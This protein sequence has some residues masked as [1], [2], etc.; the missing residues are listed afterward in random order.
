MIKQTGIIILAAGNSSRLGT[1]K[2]LLRFEGKCLLRRIVD[3]ASVH[4]DHRVLVVLG[5]AHEII[6][7]ELVG[8]KVEVVINADWED[9]MSGSIRIGLK[10]LLQ[11]NPD[12]KQCIVTVCDQPFINAGVF[13]ELGVLAKRTGKGIITTGFAGTWGVPVLFSQRYFDELLALDGQQGAKKVVKKHTE[14]MAMFPFEPARFDVDTKAD[15]Y[16]LPHQLVSVQEAGEI[17]ERYLPKPKKN[18]DVPIQDAFGYTL[19]S[20]VIAQYAIPD[21]A[22]S[23][24]DGYAIRHGELALQLKVADKIPA[25]TTVRKTLSRGEA[26]RIFTG[27]P[28]PEGA[29]TVVMQENVQVTENG[30]IWIKDNELRPGDNVRPKGSEVDKGALAIQSGTLL[31][32]AAIGYLAGVGCT[33][34]DVFEAPRVAIILTGDELKPLGDPLSFGQVYESNS[35]Q[36][37]SALNQIGIKDDGIETFHVQDDLQQLKRSVERA[38]EA[39]DILILVGGVSVGEYDYVVSAAKGCGVEQRFHR[40]RQKPGKPFFFG[41]KQEKLVFG[42]PGNPSSALT[43][44]YLYVAPALETLMQVS[45]RIKKVTAPITHDYHK[46][47]GLTHFL[48]ASYDGASV[49]P[50]HAQE[51]YRLQSFAQANCLLVLEEGNDGCKAGDEVSVYL[52]TP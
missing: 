25:G 42:L 29:D 21:F 7:N 30:S 8:A 1:P 41:T 16:R 9:G 19:A 24:M 40:I 45:H 39:C 22:Q 11:S 43:C 33:H 2:Q 34:V 36:L 20:D 44:F 32:P 13:H 52:L 47:A 48:K 17:I 26:M 51:S 12:L 28:L 38:L 14:D 5:A 6:Q 4:P 31:T 23:S 15:Y 3:A 46:K 37:R 35:Y 18:K 27:A 49:T 50:L 10:S